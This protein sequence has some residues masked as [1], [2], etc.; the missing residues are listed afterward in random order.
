MLMERMP[1]MVILMERRVE[2]TFIAK[3]VWGKR[4]LNLKKSVSIRV[5]DAKNRG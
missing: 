2:V 5:L 4:V 1:D 3:P